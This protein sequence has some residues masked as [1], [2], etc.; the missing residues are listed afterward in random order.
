[1]STAEPRC[2]HACCLHPLGAPTSPYP[3]LLLKHAEPLSKG[4]CR[5]WHH[6]MKFSCW[7]YLATSGKGLLYSLS[8]SHLESSPKY[9]NGNYSSVAYISFRGVATL[10]GQQLECS[11]CRNAI[12]ET[13]MWHCVLGRIVE[14][15]I[16]NSTCYK[17]YCGSFWNLN[18]WLHTKMFCISHPLS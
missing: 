9:L 16:W 4:H 10:Q 12:L 2:S 6:K 1:M 11:V 14:S 7:I 17:L 18:F 3:T 15:S 5:K 8:L 13:S